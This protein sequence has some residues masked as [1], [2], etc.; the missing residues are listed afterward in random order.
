[1][2]IKKSSQKT[3]KKVI[4]KLVKKNTSM[5]NPAEIS[6]AIAPEKTTAASST[7]SPESSKS[8]SKA[9]T[10]KKV[11]LTGLKVLSSKP[12]YG[13]QLTGKGDARQITTK[14]KA[15]PGNPFW[16]HF[17]YLDP[18]SIAWINATS[19]LPDIAKLALTSRSQTANEIRF[20]TKDAMLVV[21]KG[22]N[23]T[24]GDKPDPI[25]SLRFYITANYIISTR[26]QKVNAISELKEDLDKNIG[27]VDVA[28]WLVQISDI[29]ANYANAAVEQVHS[30]V[31][32]LEDS[33][34]SQQ[35]IAPHRKI[36]LIRQQLILLRRNITPQ[37]DIFMK[38]STE[39]LSWIDDNDRR[40]MHDAATGMNNY[41]N[42]IDTC[43]LRLS[44]IVEQ[45]NALLTESINKRIYI[46][47]VFATI[48]MPLTFIASLVGMNL[49]GIPFDEEPW[50]FSAYSI[51]F[52]ILGVVLCIW[53]KKKQWL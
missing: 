35:E 27:P 9:T 28:D 43:L 32:L 5:P 45:I 17:D 7:S 11:L 51:L 42:D 50:A 24:P 37:R 21:L 16:I 15:T 20:D 30:Q 13:L 1:M 40:H 18:K 3:E 49:D 36:G 33:V 25:V 31:I 2:E 12:L 10:E 14:S 29:L 44:S 34:L 6:S 52:L 39:R 19:L 38:I 48:F 22:V 46:M 23:I 4:K 41:V 26:H 47:S 53:F 8:G